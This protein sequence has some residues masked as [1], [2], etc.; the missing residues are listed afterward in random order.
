[1]A[2]YNGFGTTLSKGDGASPEVFTAVA[3]V[4]DISGPGMKADTI[5]ITN[6]SSAS[7]YREFIQGLKDAGEIKMTIQYDPAAATH[8][9]SA[10]GVLYAFEQGSKGNWKLAF[11]SSPAANWTFPAVVTGFDL[12]TPLN[13]QMTADVTFKIA[14]KPTLA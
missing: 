4:I 14:G 12:K 3:Q 13:D 8:K 11:P 1:M 9:N 10:G 5:D 2:V 6:H 7:G